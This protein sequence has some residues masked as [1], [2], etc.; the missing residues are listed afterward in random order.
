[1]A[2]DISISALAASRQQARRQ[3]IPPQNN[4]DVFLDSTYP[5]EYLNRIYNNKK[6]IDK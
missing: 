4:L 3:N 6:D 5:D 2:F 1:M